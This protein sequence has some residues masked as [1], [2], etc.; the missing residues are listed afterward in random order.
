[1]HPA[2][3]STSHALI[4]GADLCEVVF[5]LHQGGLVERGK[6][7]GD[8]V[9]DLTAY[10]RHLHAPVIYSARETNGRAVFA[11]MRPPRDGSRQSVS[12]AA[13]E[14]SGRRRNE[15]VHR[16]VLTATVAL[17]DEP[18]VGLSR[19]TIEGIAQRAGVSKAT[20]YRWWDGKTDLIVEAYLAKA[21]RDAPVPE[22]GSVRQDLVEL[23]G[24]LAFAL[25]VA[26]TRLRAAPSIPTCP[27]VGAQR[28]ANRAYLR[29]AGDRRPIS[30]ACSITQ[31]RGVGMV[32]D[33][34]AGDAASDLVERSTGSVSVRGV[35]ATSRAR[36]V[37]QPA[38]S[39][40]RTPSATSSAIAPGRTSPRAS[41]PNRVMLTSIPAPR[42]SLISTST[43]TPGGPSRFIAASIGSVG[44]AYDASG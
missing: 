20:I 15:D 3:R 17:L 35:G 13:V 16:A 11:V 39:P 41:S 22:T 19:L 44:D 24:R 25:P 12:P 2:N 27:Q 14:A 30:P 4:G 1:V 9:D 40:P 7:D 34:D 33:G 36:A 38:T 10:S 37:V 23:L 8:V 29:R 21:A 43:G 26:L 5:R 6:P 28:S 42:Q 18:T 31:R 32:A